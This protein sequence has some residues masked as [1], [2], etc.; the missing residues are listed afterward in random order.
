MFG[1]SAFAYGVNHV[2]AYFANSQDQFVFVCV[3]VLGSLVSAIWVR[4][5]ARQRQQ[6]QLMASE[7]RIRSAICFAE[8]DRALVEGNVADFMRESGRVDTDATRDEALDAFD[9]LVR[10]SIPGCLVKSM[11]PFSFPYTYLI[12]MSQT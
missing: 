5:F 6:I 8:S 3:A 12:A 1:S 9:E 11:P 4:H 10:L 7:F 2:V